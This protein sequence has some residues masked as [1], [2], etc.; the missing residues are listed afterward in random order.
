M[1]FPIFLVH[2]SVPLSPQYIIITAGTQNLQYC[3]IDNIHF[4][5]R[6]KYTIWL[7]E[8]TIM[9]HRGMGCRVLSVVSS[10]VINIV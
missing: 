2:N 9:V 10:G 8:K 3:S 1:Y 7:Q 6:F 5:Y 4:K